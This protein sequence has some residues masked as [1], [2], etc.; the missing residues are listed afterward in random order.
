MRKL[1]LAVLFAMLSLASVDALIQFD[2]A[3]TTGAPTA[4]GTK[5]PQL[6]A[7][8]TKPPND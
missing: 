6:T 5:P 7:D 1:A 2:S 4:D 3:T 8:G